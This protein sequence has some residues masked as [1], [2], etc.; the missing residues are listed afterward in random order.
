MDFG[1]HIRRHRK[2]LGYTRDGFAKLIG[3]SGPAVTKWELGE[4]FPSTKV[5]SKLARALGITVEE[6]EALAGNGLKTGNGKQIPFEDAAD[7]TDMMYIRSALE[8]LGV[9]RSNGMLDV[10]Q[11]RLLAA[12]LRQLKTFYSYANKNHIHLD[13]NEEGDQNKAEEP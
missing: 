7:M 8:E 5:F 1:E 4:S 9:I 3:V 10:N 11:V 13:E 6:L 2:A 12:M